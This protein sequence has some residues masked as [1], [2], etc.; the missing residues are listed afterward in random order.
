MSTYSLQSVFSPASVAVVGGSAREH[1]VGRAVLRNLLAAGFAGP[2]G[3]VNPNLR[4][5]EG[6]SAVARVQDLAWTPELVVIAAPQALVPKYRP[7]GRGRGGA[8]A[9]IVLNTGMGQGADSHAAE[10]A[11]VA[12]AHGLRIVGPNSL[13]VIAPH[14]RLNA[15]FAAHAPL[16]GRPR[17]D[18]AVGGDRRRRWSS[19]AS[20]AVDRFLRG[21]LARRRARCRLR[22]P[23]RLLRPRPPQ[24]RD[25]AV[26]RIDPR[27]A[28]VHVGRACRGA[29]EAGGRGEVGPARTACAR[30]RARTAAALAHRRTPCTPPRSIAPAC[31]ACAR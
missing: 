30:R 18:L 19:G 27:R 8:S 28:Q 6:V 3:L 15:S 14:A 24:P 1:S 10:L 5:I 11:S 29:I 26:R 2:V 7:R 17:G 9:A 13:G 23:A 16:P 31:C 4:E 12:R 22:R 20:A 21:R 25:P